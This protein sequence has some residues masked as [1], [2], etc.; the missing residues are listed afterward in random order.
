MKSH[1]LI[2]CSA[3]G[4]EISRNATTCPGCGQP[5][6]WVHPRIKS[7]VE[8]AKTLVTQQRFMYRIQGTELMGW[9]TP[10]SKAVFFF[11]ASAIVWV[12]FA[13]FSMFNVMQVAIMLS[14]GNEAVVI[15]VM[16][17]ELL[18]DKVFPILG[19]LGILIGI[20]LSFFSSENK[21]Q[22]SFKADFSTDPPLWECNDEGFWKPV[23]TFLGM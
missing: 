16:W 9:T 17:T 23:K 22:L 11:Q 21:H 19:I 10:K 2:V 7:F 3:C 13:L 14:N 1:P 8:D 15:A 20:V 4:K 12:I 6:N 18:I 5:N